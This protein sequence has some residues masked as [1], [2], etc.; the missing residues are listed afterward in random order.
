MIIAL[1]FTGAF[2]R[3]QI[4]GLRHYTNQSIAAFGVAAD[5]TKR[6]GGQVK[7]ALA[8]ANLTF[9]GEQSISELLYLLLGLI[10]QMQGQTLGCAW[11]NARQTLELI[12]Q[13]S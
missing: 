5:L 4:A 13:P 10:E 11:A 2:H 9:C 1:K 7:T 3:Q 12:D 8:L 6:I